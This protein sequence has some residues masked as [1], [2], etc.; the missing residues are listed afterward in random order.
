M[1]LPLMRLP[2]ETW[3]AMQACALTG[4][5]TGDALAHR[6]ELNPLSHTNQG[7]NSRFNSLFLG[8][9]IPVSHEPMNPTSFS[10]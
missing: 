6:L 1:W 7:W 5:H 9:R 10:L 3:P 4:Y 2:L 8:L